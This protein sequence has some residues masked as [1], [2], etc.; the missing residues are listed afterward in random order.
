MWDELLNF[1]R[2]LRANFRWADL[3]D[4]GVIAFCL[5]F[6]LMWL[7]QRSSRSVLVVILLVCSVYALA[8][9]LDMYL[10]LSL[11]QVGFTVILVVLVL[12]FQDDL[13]RGFERIAAWRLLSG[14]SG[15]PSETA[16]N[17]L[18]EAVADLAEKR[19]GALIVL[20]GEEPLERHVRGGVRV[21]G[22]ISLPLVLS[23][24]HPGSPGHDGAMLLEGNRIVQLGVHLPLS[25]NLAEVGPGSTRHTAALGL[26][27][28]CDA[29]VVVVSEE[30]GTISVAEH[31]H[32]E[33]LESAAAL[34]AR[35]DHHSRS[36]APTVEKLRWRD[37]VRNPEIKS[38][39]FVLACLLWLAFAYHVDTVQRPYE[40][41]PVEFRNVP[42]NREVVN[43][44]PT[45]VLV[46]V[47]GS[48][49]DVNQFDRKSLAVSIDLAGLPP[50]TQRLPITARSINL[51]PGLTVSRIDPPEVWVEL[52]TPTSTD[53]PRPPLRNG[54]ARRR[55]AKNDEVKQAVPPVL[56]RVGWALPTRIRRN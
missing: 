41:V 56:S 6:F 53:Q 50:G 25:N 21:D 3:L 27:E 19:I 4:I 1:V 24:F 46:I 35:I 36:L 40:N 45:A 17:T 39:S 20:P 5:Y 42:A 31:G 2:D 16:T 54:S 7:L 28:R 51:P 47:S 18:V 38:F 23:I 14:R 44:S 8:R 33:I 10:T 37:W 30:R 15:L 11:F 12:I 34:H 13:R 29:L 9:W 22:R 48:E 26:S 55:R 43:F 52:S 32:L 49:R